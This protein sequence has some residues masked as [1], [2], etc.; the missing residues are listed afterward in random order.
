MV[1]MGIKGFSVLGLR[2]ELFDIEKSEA[3]HM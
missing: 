3:W 1:G 2:T